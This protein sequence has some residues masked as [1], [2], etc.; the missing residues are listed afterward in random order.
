MIKCLECGRTINIDEQEPEVGDILACESCG[1]E[2][3]VISVDPVE[4]EL[5]EEE[6]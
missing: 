6:K 4:V 5:V 1:T 2:H 3:E